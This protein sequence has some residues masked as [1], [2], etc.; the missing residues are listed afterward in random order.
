MH[1]CVLLERAMLYSCIA[2]LQT[3]IILIAGFYLSIPRNPIYLSYEYFNIRNN[4]TDIK[5]LIY[6]N[7]ES[8][9]VY[10]EVTICSLYCD[11]SLI[12]FHICLLKESYMMHNEENTRI[13]ERTMLLINKIKSTKEHYFI[14]ISQLGIMPYLEVLDSPIQAY[15]SIVLFICHFLKF[16]L[17][18]PKF[19]HPAQLNTDRFST[20]SSSKNGSGCLEKILIECQLAIIYGTGL[21]V[22]DMFSFGLGIITQWTIFL[23]RYKVKSN[24]NFDT[25]IENGL[26]Y[27]KQSSKIEVFNSMGTIK[28]NIIECIKIKYI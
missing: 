23:I 22:A 7:D 8:F 1:Q 5:G 21:R 11:S 19:Y 14:A 27:L 12:A 4:L 28:A 20:Y 24:L 15:G 6:V 9:D 25:T 3:F 13:I 2:M 10:C 17:L 18:S 16:F 26:N